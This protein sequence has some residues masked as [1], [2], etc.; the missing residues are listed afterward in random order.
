MNVEKLTA[1]IQSGNV[2]MAAIDESVSRILTPMFSVG[3]MDEPVETYL[4]LHC[5]CHLLP[6]LH[7]TGSSALKTST[8][9]PPN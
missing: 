8:M 7:H 1:G 4:L 2:T 3:V 5:P 6:Q 9:Q